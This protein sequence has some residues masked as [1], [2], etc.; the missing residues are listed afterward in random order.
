MRLNLDYEISFDIE[1]IH[2]KLKEAGWKREDWA[3]FTLDG[4]HIQV[5]PR[6]I[7][8]TEVVDGRMRR[9]VTT[10][11]YACEIV[12]SD[13][14]ELKKEI[15]FY[16]ALF[17]DGNFPLKPFKD[18]DARGQHF[19]VE[20]SGLGKGWYKA[21]FFINPDYSQGYWNNHSI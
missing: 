14:K 17:R 19:R 3:I 1:R 8:Y 7:S 2:N 20:K 21:S 5:V 6:L 10:V 9:E 16:E 12:A 15:E 18:E 13:D 4:H 11:W